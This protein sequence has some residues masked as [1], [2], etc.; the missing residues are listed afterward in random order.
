MMLGTGCAHQAVQNDRHDTDVSA[1]AKNQK[2]ENQAAAAPTPS[3]SPQTRRP[4]NNNAADDDT[5]GNERTASRSKAAKKTNE[6]PA[7]T[8][9]TIKTPMPP[10]ILL[11]QTVDIKFGQKHSISG[12]EI[13]FKISKI[14]D[15]RCPLE[16]QC[17]HQ[18]SAKVTLTIYETGRRVG[19]VYLDSRGI[20]QTLLDTPIQQY[21]IQLV[22]LMPYPTVQFTEPRQYVAQIIVNKNTP[23][24]P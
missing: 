23:V 16:M 3:Q 7:I 20:E 14:D 22:D 13:S 6:N 5:R 1:R 8:R 24:D 12:T 17:D 11:G 2:P 4:I 18:G 15:Q 10:S 9:R 21:A 19:R